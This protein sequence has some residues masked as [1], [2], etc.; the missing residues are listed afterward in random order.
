MSKVIYTRGCDILLHTTVFTEDVDFWRFDGAERDKRLKNLKKICQAINIT[1]V[2]TVNYSFCGNFVRIIENADEQAMQG[3]GNAIITN[4][5]DIALIGYAAM[6]CLVGLV[7]FDGKVRSVI[8]VSDESLKAGIINK[9]IT[10]FTAKYGVAKNEIAAYIG[11]CADKCCQNND[12]GDFY[13]EIKESLKDNGIETMDIFGKNHY[14]CA[15][16]AEGEP[17]F[18][19]YHC[20]VLAV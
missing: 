9:T 11:A 4:H 8:H 15:E 16:N 20:M 7:S 17:L 3:G 13:E 1:K 18:S 12:N 2:A 6:D 14:V 10:V 19:N 5:S